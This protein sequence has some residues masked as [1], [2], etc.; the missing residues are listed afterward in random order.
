MKRFDL[1]NEP[2]IEPGFKIPDNYFDSFEERLMQK[3]P[4][5]RNEVKVISLW[6][7]KSVWITSA[8]AMFIITFGTWMYFVQNNVEN[9]ISTQEYLVYESDITTED[10]A[11]NLTDADIST[12]ENELNLY[13][14]ES[15]TYLNEYVD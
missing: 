14:T 13:N 1:D 3:L 6:Q 4:T 10:I 2:K 5:E 9:T 15:E 11:M 12:I 7:R 8:A